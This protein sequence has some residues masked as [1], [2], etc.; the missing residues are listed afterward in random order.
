MP[1]MIDE[2]TPCLENAWRL[3]IDNAFSVTAE[4]MV[5]TTVSRKIMKVSALA[6]IVNFGIDFRFREEEFKRMPTNHFRSAVYRSH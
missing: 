1:F 2:T 6:C 3:D 4:E 5:S